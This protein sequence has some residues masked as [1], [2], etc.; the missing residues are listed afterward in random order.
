[1]IPAFID[2]L[3]SMLFHSPIMRD[4][5]E[6]IARSSLALIGAVLLAGL[7][8]RHSAAI[9]HFVLSLGVVAAVVTPIVASLVPRWTLPVLP[10][11]DEAVARVQP[12]I[13]AIEARAAVRAE[14][15]VRVEVTRP[16]TA[17]AKVAESAA[18]IVRAPDRGVAPIEIAVGMPE[19]GIATS[20]VVPESVAGGPPSWLA[21][22]SVE[23][24]FLIVGWLLGAIV[25]FAPYAASRASMARLRRRARPVVD[26][27]WYDA[28]RRALASVSLDRD[29][30]VLESDD[31]TMPMT[32][33]IIRPVVLLPREGRS[34]S[35]D[36]RLRAVRHE[37][38]HIERRDCFTLLV[39]RIVCSLYWFNPF[40]WY[41]AARLRAESEHACDDIVLRHGARPSEYAQQLVD[42]VR[43]L[44]SSAPVPLH[45]LPMA[46]RSQ[47]GDRVRAILDGRRS[48]SRVTPFF[49][50]VAAFLGLSMVGALAAITPVSAQ[51]TRG[52]VAIARVRVPA[53]SSPGAGSV[54]APLAATAVTVAG[55]TGAATVSAITAVTSASP[56][57]A[58]TVDGVVIDLPG[59]RP[60]YAIASTSPNDAGVVV[61]VPLP[62]VPVQ[63]AICEPRAGE[64]GSASINHVTGR[65]NGRDVLDVK[66]SF[67]DCRMT[68]RVDG[69]YRL[70]DGG[71]DI[72][73]L[74]EDGTFEL[75]VRDGR[76][77]RRVRI[78]ENDGRLEREYWVNGRTAEYDASASA[79][80]AGA[81]IAVD[82]RTAFAVDVRL[83][84]LLSSGGVEAVLSEVG[85]MCCDYAKRVYITKLSSRQTLG[86][87]HVRQILQNLATGFS[88]DY[89]R[90]EL[91]IGLSKQSAFAE[92]THDE[93]VDAARGIKSDYEMRRVMTALL[94]KENLSSAVVAAL[95]D[96]TSNIQSDYE[97]AELL[98]GVSKRYAMTASTRPYYVR[99]LTSL[100]SDYEH[101]RVLDA[102]VRG[103]PLDAATTRAV[104]EDAARIGSDYELAEFLIKI[105]N[106]GFLEDSDDAFFTAVGAIQG[107]YEHGRVL[108]SVI[109]KRKGDLG[110]AERVLLSARGIESDYECAMLLLRVAEVVSI[111]GRVRD[112][113][114]KAA[115]TIGSEYE[116]GRAMKALRTRAETAR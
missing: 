71:N 92:S 38:A 84:R 33:G 113:Y 76:L 56:V 3:D 24:A 2:T 104:L 62:P 11:R 97:L 58:R 1:M 44:R 112:A 109:A 40:A 108:K 41:A 102:I 83:P 15:P 10:A 17:P 111:D 34:W 26:G 22:I 70:A 77:T 45:A 110:F 82:R 73:W 105:G 50:C 57:S 85:R 101:R 51:I 95:L 63:Q 89:E 90:A 47:V 42:V 32:W 67:G 19:S 6:A 116:Y 48:R 93:F 88:S 64:S 65:R 35:A 106:E 94:G 21:S 91:L 29:V 107:D 100:D 37:L 66:W 59:V 31:A 96:A 8:R 23:L 36:R 55:A 74:E 13:A 9:R 115:E 27:S 98:I 80:L 114:E 4:V 14:A 5:L 69:E 53:T 16:A 61:M 30:E 75:E 68:L 18:V 81:I 46:R 20:L 79:W 87:T 78:E 12:V 7:L 28:T 72:A 43:S 86:T 39:A 99:A 54:S 60:T 49:A 52:P 103:G 25:A